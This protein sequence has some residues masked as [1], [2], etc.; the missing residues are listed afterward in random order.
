MELID[1]KE[2]NDG[3]LKANKEANKGKSNLDI[4]QALFKYYKAVYST[5][6]ANKII[7]GVYDIIQGDW[8][9]NQ[10]FTSYELYRDLKKGEKN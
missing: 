2:L 1:I 9:T 5:R 4:Q 7:K 10:N 3:M 8:I 6:L